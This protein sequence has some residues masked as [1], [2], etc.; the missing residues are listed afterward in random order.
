ML[1]RFSNVNNAVK[2][3]NV[4]ALCLHIY[5][6]I[7]IRDHI[8]VIFAEN[9]FIK[10]PT[11][12]NILIFILVRF[13][14][15]FFPLIFPIF[16]HKNQPNR[17]KL[18]CRYSSNYGKSIYQNHTIRL[19]HYHLPTLC[20]TITRKYIM[21]LFFKKYDLVGMVHLFALS[22]IAFRRQSLIH[23]NPLLFILLNY[24]EW[25][26]SKLTISETWIKMERNTPPQHI[27]M[28]KKKY[29][30]ILRAYQNFI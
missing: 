19:W 5:L 26:N 20:V 22:H 8:H 21:E 12:R 2:H 10:S 27:F 23:I 24:A 18:F 7:Q 13:Y 16:H 14:C 3:L 4:Q 29:I 9:D 6:Y 25:L 17:L 30:I 11:W 15:I 28:S 1:K